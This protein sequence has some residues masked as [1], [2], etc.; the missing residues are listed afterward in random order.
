[1][2]FSDILWRFI[3]NFLLKTAGGSGNPRSGF[4]ATVSPCCG[5]AAALSPYLRFSPEQNL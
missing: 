5:K 1:M 2:I 4:K 3:V